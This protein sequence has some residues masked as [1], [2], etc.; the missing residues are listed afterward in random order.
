M[1]F[2]LGEI[3]ARVRELLANGLTGNSQDF[4]AWIRMDTLRRFREEPVFPPDS[5]QNVLDDLVSKKEAAKGKLDPR[6]YVLSPESSLHRKPSKKEEYLIL[7][8]V[9][10]QPMQYVRSRME[11]FLRANGIDE[12]LIVDL[13]IGSIEAVENAVKYGDGGT[14]EV[15]YSIE[16]ENVFK[17]RLVNNLRELNIE[18]DIERGKFSSTATLMRGMMVMQKLFDKLDLEILEDKR[19]ALFLAEKRLPK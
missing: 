13:T 1:S 7:G 2:S 5:V 18:E 10:F 8:R 19:Q 12:D 9:E 14:V 6:E 11:S 16:K 17:I 15:S 3:E 4:H